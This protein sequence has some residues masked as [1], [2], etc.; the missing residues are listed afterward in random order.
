MK[1]ILFLLMV[2]AFCGCNLQE[3]EKFNLGFEVQ[4]KNIS[5]A[6]GWS[7]TGD[8][9]IE[10]VSKAKSGK[11]ACKISNQNDEGSFG[12]V[13]YEIPAKYKGRSIKLEGFLKLNKV[14][15]GF[16]SLTIKIDDKNGFPLVIEYM[17]DE[18]ITG[19]FDWKKYSLSV[20]YPNEAV[21]IVIGV[22]L[23]GQGEA[24]F[25]DLTLSIDDQSVQV[26]EEVGSPLAKAQQ[27][28]TF[29][30]GSSITFD[31]LDAQKVDDLVVLGRVWGFLKYYHPQIAKGNY[32][33]DYELFR[34]LPQF[35]GLEAEVNKDKLLL[36]WID[37]LGKIET[38]HSCQP[39]S[40]D[41]ILKPD[42]KWIEERSEAL[43]KK[44]LWVY[45]NRSQG[46]HYYFGRETAENPRFR[47]EPLYT[48]SRY[49]DDGF[50]LLCLYRYWNIINYFY[51][52]KYLTNEDWNKQLKKYIPLFIN[53]SDEIKYELAVLRLI[54]EINDTHAYL[55]KGVNQIEYLK[56]LKYA[57][58]QTRFIENH[59][60]VTGY[61]KAELKD[62]M[63]LK[64]G[65]IISKINGRNV[66]QIVDSL[67]LYY[68]ASNKP[69][70]LRNI[71]QDILR[72]NASSVKVEYIQASGNKKSTS[73]TL[74]PKSELDLLYPQ[75][76]KLPHTSIFAPA[77]KETSSYK[78]LDHNI[79]YLSLDSIRSSDLPSIKKALMD[80]KGIIVDIRNYPSDF[81]PFI[82][83]SFFIKKST[84][85]VKFSVVNF[86]NPGEFN[87]MEGTELKKG[88]Q[89]FNGP[90]VVL[91]NERSQSQSE[92][93][94]MALR[95][96]D[97][98]TIVGSTTAGA[99]G[100]VSK[101]NLPGGLVT[102]ISGL[103]IYYPD[104]G[105]TQQIGI[106]P[107]IHVEPT[108]EGIRAGKDEVLEKAIEVILYQEE[109]L[110]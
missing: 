94:A 21:N 19:T 22:A 80:T 87:F 110:K 85:F 54:G 66:E 52:Y 29:D 62:S 69:T 39:A 47:N 27:D 84:P 37:S 38:C 65:D 63:D 102:L 77:K 56:G 103:G 13:T 70:K 12:L 97:N 11:K 26:L 51:P 42:L 67:T 28:R 44:L 14:K 33:W 43:Q 6:K 10:I 36:D 40:K 9:N 83:G 76:K 32:N 41:A 23:T 64:K 73:I 5:F 93:T 107:D 92:Y 100:N 79:G 25:D 74:Y 8:Y 20:D 50:R 72:S 55:G 16:A 58:I 1:N 86:D 17:Q 104:G 45:N 48:F 2:L 35:L 101:I 109:E 89:Y 75:N 95:A 60:V 30:K 106:V 108:I 49:P 3:V 7:K 82:L 18:N 4:D 98:T 31:D 46:R 24:W 71:A 88:E 57:P 34:F 15:D 78:I 68:P 105:E 91:V 59:L 81:V 61:L 96:G 99:D 90:L 53:A